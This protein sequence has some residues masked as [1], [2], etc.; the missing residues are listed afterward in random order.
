MGQRRLLGHKCSGGFSEDDGGRR[1]CPNPRAEPSPPAPFT[2]LFASPVSILQS[3]AGVPE[4]S[5]GLMPCLCH[6][7]WEGSWRIL[8]RGMCFSWDLGGN[9][10]VPAG[11]SQGADRVGECLG[12][13]LAPAQLAAAVLPLCRAL[14]P[15]LSLGTSACRIY[16]SCLR[17]R[18]QLVEL[19]CSS[20]CCQGWGWRR[21][22]VPLLL[23]RD[24]NGCWWVLSRVGRLA[25]ISILVAPPCFMQT[26]IISPQGSDAFLEQLLQVVLGWECLTL[27]RC[28]C[29]F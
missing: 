26:Q 21:N 13:M 22:L 10:V 6:A 2:P 4:M 17:C 1:Q 11:L 15:L 19:C 27:H 8:R 18:Q 20:G 25:R 28:A 7:I 24:E 23:Q 3:C 9:C 29:A 12:A 16:K 5:E 14:C